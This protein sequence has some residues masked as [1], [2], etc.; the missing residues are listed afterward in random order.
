VE[1]HLRNTEN[2]AIE[3]M[4]LSIVLS[5]Q[6]ASFSAMAYQGQLTSNLKKI[7]NMGFD[8][9]ELAIRNPQKLN[10]AELESLLHEQDLQVSAIGTGQLYGEDGLSFTHHDAHI[11]KT[12]IDRISAHLD[13]GEKWNAVV[14]I[15][16]IRGRSISEAEKKD[17]ESRL[18]ESLHTCA[19]RHEK[20]K[21]A[22]EPINRYETNLLNTVDECL[23]FLDRLNRENVGL[24]LDSFH[25]NIEEPSITSS[26]MNARERLFH[27]HV[28]DSNRWYPGA[29]HIDFT[30]IIQ[31][32]RQIHSSGFISGEM[33]PFP[34]P[35][36]S[37]RNMI[38]F[39]K[40]IEK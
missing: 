25:M 23:L 35:D 39:L 2:G 10:I 34:D 24:L 15:G 4:K 27:V 8:G 13:L 6:P 22:I 14:I 7:K 36:S 9:V 20:V 18:L 28:A 19:S 40:N 31:T 17:A 30:S 32:L 11:R 21:M 16:L 3:K 38:N 33:L 5:T 37:A 1:T 12:A 26:F 29:G